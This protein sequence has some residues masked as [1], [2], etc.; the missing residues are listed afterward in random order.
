MS[1][2]VRLNDRWT[3]DFRFNDLDE[4]GAPLLRH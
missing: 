1:P 4:R 2:R 3:F